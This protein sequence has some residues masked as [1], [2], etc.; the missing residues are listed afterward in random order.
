MSEQHTWEPSEDIAPHGVT[1]GRWSGTA[2]KR[3]SHT[4]FSTKFMV[5]TGTLSQG[6]E[7]YGPFDTEVDA[8]RW[9]WDNLKP[10]TKKNAVHIEKFNHVGS[11]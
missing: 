1:T 9:V 7:F 11:E 6:F 4:V 2:T 8:E 5:V 10:I 3:K